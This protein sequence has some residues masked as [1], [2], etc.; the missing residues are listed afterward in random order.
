[1]KVIFKTKRENIKK[2]GRVKRI[3]GIKRQNFQSW[4][5][6]LWEIQ[7]FLGLNFLN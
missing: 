4:F 1:M 2:K 6:Q 3:L 7:L 5:S